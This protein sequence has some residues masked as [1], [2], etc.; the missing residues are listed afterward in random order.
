MVSQM[1]HFTF[2]KKFF[3]FLDKQNILHK[4]IVLVKLMARS[5]N[6]ICKI[7]ITLHNIIHMCLP[8]HKVHSVTVIDTH[9]HTHTHTE[10]ETSARHG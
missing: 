2:I 5:S 10:R 6:S 9:T 3:F 7:Q 8:D 4:L 1:R